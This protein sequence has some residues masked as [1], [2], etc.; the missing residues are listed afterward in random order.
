MV[1]RVDTASY[2]VI[3]SI[4]DDTFKGGTVKYMDVAGD[5]VS[6]TDFSVMKESLGDKFPQ[7]IVDKIDELADKSNQAKL[8]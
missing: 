5:G 8:S 2:E 4:T 6:L 7:D 1:K 3:K